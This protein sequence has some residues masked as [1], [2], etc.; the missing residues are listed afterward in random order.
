MATLV[1]R[2]GQTPP[3]WRR[4]IDCV[5]ASFSNHGSLGV[6]MAAILALTFRRVARRRAPIGRLSTLPGQYAEHGPDAPLAVRGPNAPGGLALPGVGRFCRN[7]NGGSP[8]TGR[9]MVGDQGGGVS[10]P[11][12]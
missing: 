11:P 2:A 3:W 10:P 4:G 8:R 1:S 9:S 7:P 12:L 6:F 5:G